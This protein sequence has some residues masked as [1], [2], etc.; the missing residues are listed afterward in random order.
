MKQ[1]V[2]IWLKDTAQPF[3]H[4]AVNTFQ[5]GDLFCVCVGGNGQYDYKYP[6]ANIFRIREQYIQEIKK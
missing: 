3:V 6:I 1:I 4:V 5:K 2:T